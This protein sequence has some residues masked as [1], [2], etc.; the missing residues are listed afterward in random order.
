MPNTKE[1][2]LRFAAHSFRK[3]G[4]KATSMRIIA[5]EIGIQ[6]PSI[7]NHFDK[8]EDILEELLMNVANLFTK[9][10]KEINTNFQS[11]TEKMEK[12]IEL[13]VQLTI[14][15]TDAIALIPSEWIY[16]KK[17][18]LKKYTRLR[19]QYENDF[20]EILEE[21]K[22]KKEFNIVDTEIAMFSI[23][24]TLRWLYT[25]Y[26]KNISSKPEVLN[27]QMVRCL[28]EGIKR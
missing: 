6:A 17:S 4:Y 12:L 24:S 2:I 3:V 28:L 20:K 10:M 15:H 16:L 11:P 7:Y 27:E 18:T 22:K 23:L 26:S 13:H 25:W 1:N 19:D 21:G 8:K 5:K 14:E 9:G